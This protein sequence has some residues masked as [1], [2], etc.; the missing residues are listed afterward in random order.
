[1]VH[2]HW[3]RQSRSSPR[4][5]TSTFHEEDAA[6]SVASESDRHQE[7]WVR[8]LV[9]FVDGATTVSVNPGVA[10]GVAAAVLLGVAETWTVNLEPPDSELRWCWPWGPTAALEA[11]AP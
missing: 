3:C 6:S 8:W 1:M 5:V 10:F 4:A 7:K 11:H 2:P 9:G